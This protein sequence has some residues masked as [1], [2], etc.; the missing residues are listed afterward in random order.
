MRCR[1][2]IQSQHKPENRCVIVDRG[3]NFPARSRV[4][5]QVVVRIG[6]ISVGTGE[7]RAARLRNCECY[8]SD[9]DGLDL[10]EGPLAMKCPFVYSSGR[11]CTGDVWQARAYGHHRDGIVEPG[12]IRKIRLWCS[13]KGDHAGAVSSFGS[14]E[15]MEFY[16]DE[17]HRRGLYAEA[18]TLC[19]NVPAAEDV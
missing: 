18:L 13:E 9:G 10:S 8:A 1:S 2:E 4:G 12:D 5:D 11:H 19:D 14:K 17:L 6:P 3:D 16:P 15:R 7:G